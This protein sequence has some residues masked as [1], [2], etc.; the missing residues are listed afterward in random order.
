VYGFAAYRTPDLDGVADLLGLTAED[1]DAALTRTATKTGETRLPL[2]MLAYA[3]ACGEN[4]LDHIHRRYAYN[5][6]LGAHWLTV[7]RRPRLPTE[8]RRAAGRRRRS[9]PGRGRRR[10][11]RRQRGDGRRLTAQRGAHLETRVGAGLLRCH[12]K[13]DEDYRRVPR[14]HQSGPPSTWPPPGRLIRTF[15]CRVS[16]R[17]SWTSAR[18]DHVH[19]DR[20]GGVAQPMSGLVLLIE[21]ALQDRLD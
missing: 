5:P 4:N 16:G 1:R 20:P 15:A 9:P 6:A 8:R 7:N 3:A 21:K 2:L 11:R 17:G 13:H 18:R 10:R 14:L 12:R 19:A